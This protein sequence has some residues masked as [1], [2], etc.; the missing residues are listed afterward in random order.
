MPVT[1]LARGVR[2]T[3]GADGGGSDPLTNLAVVVAA[4]VVALLAGTV[5]GPWRA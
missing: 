1:F 2:A 4:A 5:A 3:T